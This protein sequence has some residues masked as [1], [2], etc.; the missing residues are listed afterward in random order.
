M[1]DGHRIITNANDWMRSVERRLASIERRPA[2]QS[3]EQ[4]LGETIAPISMQ[5][6][7]WNARENLLNGWYW[8]EPP[9][10]NAPTLVL[11]LLGMAIV[12]MVPDGTRAGIQVLWSEQATPVQYR[13]TF[14]L[15]PDT[16]PS[17][18]AWV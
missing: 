5:V 16:A 15:V 10:A 13:R 18:G 17:F 4:I 3:R 7:D 1:T 14:L 12:R 8:S 2:V 6:I 9:A 11:P